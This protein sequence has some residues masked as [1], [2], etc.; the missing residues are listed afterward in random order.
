MKVNW[1]RVVAIA[2][3]PLFLYTTWQY[4]EAQARYAH[5]LEH[6]R[7]TSHVKPAPAPTTPPAAALPTAPVAK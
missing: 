5:L 1:W 7:K 4:A 3:V 6:V 2:A